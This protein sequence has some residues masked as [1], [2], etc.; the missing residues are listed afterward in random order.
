MAAAGPVGP[1]HGQL[2]LL[3]ESSVGEIGRQSP[4]RRGRNTTG[5]GDCLGRVAAVEIALGHELKVRNGAPAVGQPSFADKTGRNIRRHDVREGS[6]SLKN[7]WLAG[8]AAGEESVIGGA[9]RL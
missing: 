7:Q 2:D 3:F 1:W 8:L 6:R 5:L 9:R 4:D